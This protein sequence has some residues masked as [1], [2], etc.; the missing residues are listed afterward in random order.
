MYLL[1]DLIANAVEITP[2]LLQLLTPVLT[3]LWTGPFYFSCELG[4]W[5]LTYLLIDEVVA[6]VRADRI[7]LGVKQTLS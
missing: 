4:N 7:Y 6:E 5:H 1:F 2:T 3:T